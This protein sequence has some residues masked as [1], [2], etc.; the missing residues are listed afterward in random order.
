MENYSDP[1]FDGN[2]SSSR[3]I[4]NRV[5][6]LTLIAALASV[7]ALVILYIFILSNS[8]SDRPYVSADAYSSEESFNEFNATAA[9]Q[10]CL[11]LQFGRNETNPEA[12]DCFRESLY[13]AVKF[14]Q[15]DQVFALQ[16]QINAS[17]A[18]GPCHSGAHLAGVDL[19]SEAPMHE[20]LPTLFGTVV[21]GK[22]VVC[23]T[24]L[25]HGLVQGSALGA[26]PFD[27]LYLAE[28]CIS[29]QDLKTDYAVEC[30]HYFG[31]VAYKN[32]NSLDDNVAKACELLEEKDRSGMVASCVGG[33]L[34]QK[35]SLQDDTYNPTAMDTEI[36]SLDPPSY[37]ESTRMCS[38]YD[39][40]PNKAILESCWNGIGWLLAMRSAKNINDLDSTSPA[41]IT[42]EYIT[43]VNY[44]EFDDCTYTYLLHLRPE[45][46]DSK[47]VNNLCVSGDV[48]VTPSAAPFE[49][50]CEFIVASLTGSEV[51]ETNSLYD[52]VYW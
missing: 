16:D 44:C 35:T 25:V 15:F 39:S 33:A 24:G 26:P 32:Y 27:L 1:V 41:D 51:S 52:S 46:H 22:D 31:H 34:M 40:Y 28:Q 48:T 47:A 21:P 10:E 29:I 43:G 9:L 37:E 45:D 4:S 38:H 13:L 7:V 6:L 12:T 11:K 23:T 30:A 5:V 8:T 18:Y 14:D 2:T 50:M 17:G 49:D 19:V 36:V 42:R 3:L 20:I